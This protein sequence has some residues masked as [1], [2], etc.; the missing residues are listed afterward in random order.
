MY[1]NRIDKTVSHNNL[2]SS[3]LALRVGEVRDYKEFM[4][5]HP[6]LLQTNNFGGIVIGATYESVEIDNDLNNSQTI[7]PVKDDS[8]GLLPQKINF[9]EDGRL[10]GIT[11]SLEGVVIHSPSVSGNFGNKILTLH[12]LENSPLAEEVLFYGRSW[13]AGD[14]YALDTYDGY[15]VS[16]YKGSRNSVDT[17]GWKIRLAESLGAYSLAC[18]WGYCCLATSSSMSFIHIAILV[19]LFV[20][21][22]ATII[23]SNVLGVKNKHEKNLEF[24]RKMINAHLAEDASSMNA[25]ANQDDDADD[26]LQ[27]LQYDINNKSFSNESVIANVNS[28]DLY[29][30]CPMCYAARIDTET[31]CICCGASLIKNS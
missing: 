10:K 14:G 4:Q 26:L 12:D 20:I 29:E 24:T 28:D 6:E 25:F 16:H 19:I 15:F 11:N 9:R 2:N 8:G 30:Y 18:F 3:Y 13:V 23:I 17:N 7:M 1:G 5:A 21:F 27:E 31:T 22:G